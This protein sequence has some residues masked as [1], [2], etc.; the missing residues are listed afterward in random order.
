[1][2]EFTSAAAQG[3]AAGRDVLFTE[4]AVL[5]GNC[6]ILHREGSGLVTLRGLTNQ[7]RALYQVDYNGN[8]A[9]PTGGTVGEISLAI[10]I[11]GE[12]LPASLARITPAA[13]DQFGNVSAKAQIAV[14]RGCCVEC[15]V[16]NTS[17]QAITVANSNLVVTRIA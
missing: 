7:F 15:S 12:A 2:A 5:P 14:V 11:N 8:I 4:T 13:V 10:A 17:D 1:M 6:S 16:Q 9:I 3:V